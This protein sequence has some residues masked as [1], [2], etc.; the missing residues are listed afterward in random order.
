MKMHK[1]LPLAALA[2][3]L[4]TNAVAL[5]GAAWNRQGE[6]ES[7]LTL[8]QRELRLPYRGFDHESSGL[9][10]MLNWRVAGMTGNKQ[11]YWDYYNG[12]EPEWLDKAKMQ[13]L[14][15][16]PA[17][18]AGGDTRRRHDRALSRDVLLVL[19]FAGEASRKALEQARQH[20]V[21]EE[22]KWAA[23]PDSIEKKNRLREAAERLLREENESSR[24]FVVDAGLDA[25]VLRAKYPDRQR[26]AIVRGQ[27]SPFWNSERNSGAARGQVS[28]VSIAGINVPYAY[29]NFL[30]DM[31]VHKKFT[32]DVAFGQRL[33]PWID[34][35]E[36]VSR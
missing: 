32:A 13:S 9:M 11:P 21:A 10:L 15:F 34:Q 3:I 26:F 22:E 2:L 31:T 30:G 5:G 19:E 7:R 24:L 17:P 1:L 23:T 36:V 12:G 33:E 20:L 18:S 29:R 25:G 14:G 16:D 8:S 4:L 35:I 28:K 6:P 27:V